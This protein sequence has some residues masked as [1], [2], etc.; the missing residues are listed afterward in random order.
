MLSNWLI[1]AA[2]WPSISNPAKLCLCQA[3][4]KQVQQQCDL[5]KKEADTAQRQVQDYVQQKHKREAELYV[6]VGRSAEA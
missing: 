3:S 6:K 2:V 4:Q 1:C 5:F